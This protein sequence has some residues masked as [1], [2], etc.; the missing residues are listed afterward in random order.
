M[1]FPLRFDIETYDEATY[2]PKERKLLNEIAGNCGATRDLFLVQPDRTLLLRPSP[3]EKF[4]VVDCLL[5][6]VKKAGLV[7]VMPMGFLGNAAPT[8]G[9]K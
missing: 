1:N 7:N 5:A 9:G 2:Y 8:E 4:Q 6:G 3:E